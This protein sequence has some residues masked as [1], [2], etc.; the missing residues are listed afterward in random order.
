MLQRST[1]SVSLQFEQVVVVEKIEVVVV[2]I[3]VV[4]EVV[5]VVVLVVVVV[6]VVVVVEVVVDVVVVVGGSTHVSV[7]R[8]HVC[9]GAQKRQLLLESHHPLRDPPKILSASV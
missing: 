5:V 8:S 9:S 7:E 1:H 3:V 4:V 2:P 6:V